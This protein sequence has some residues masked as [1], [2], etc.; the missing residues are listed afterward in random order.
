MQSNRIKR[1]ISKYLSLVGSKLNVVGQNIQ[2]AIFKLGAKLRKIPKKAFIIGSYVL[3]IIF[4]SGFILFRFDYSTNTPEAQEYTE[5]SQVIDMQEIFDELEEREEESSLDNEV[6]KTL[7][8]EEEKKT[9]DGEADEVSTEKKDEK[10]SEKVASPEEMPESI[11][12]IEGEIITSHEELYQVNNQHRFHDGIDIKAPKGTDIV[13]AW[14]GQ[15][16]KVKENTTYGLKL[17]VSGEGYSYS[18]GNLESVKVNEGQEVNQGDVI[19][20]V[21][22]SAVLDAAEGSYLHF[23]VSIKDDAIDPE[24]VLLDDSH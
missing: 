15:I 4:L 13:A 12:P 19:A 20:T 10:E 6:E 2:A 21:G 14:D 9:L 24:R 22:T 1:L 16:D 23:S 18:Y 11:W 17:S 5:E 7:D 8:I 3:V